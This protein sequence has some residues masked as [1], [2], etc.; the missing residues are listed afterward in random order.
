MELILIR[1]GTTQGNKERRFIGVLDVPLATEGE[2]LAR[3]VAPT[4]PAVDHVY[5]S[6]LVRCAQTAELLWP[7]A[8]E[9]VIPQLRETDFGPFEGKNHEE[10]KDDPLYQQWIS[11]ADFA[12]IPVGESAEDAVERAGEGLEILLSDAKEHGYER[13]GVVSHGGTLMGLLWRF[14][15]PEREYYDWMCPNCGGY[16]A[17]V[18]EDPLTLEILEPIGGGG[19]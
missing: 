9:T 19:Q 12:K 4:L 15:R 7:E 1:H 18:H 5:R 11:A 3:R 16:R 8:E 6:P 10:L 2:E 13:V 14:G 17:L